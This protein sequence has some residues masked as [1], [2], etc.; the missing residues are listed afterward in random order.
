MGCYEGPALETLRSS[1]TTT[2][3]AILY[4]IQSHSAMERHGGKVSPAIEHKSTCREGTRTWSATALKR[5]ARVLNT[6]PLPRLAS[7]LP[8]GQWTTPTQCTLPLRGMKLCT[9]YLQWKNISF[10]NYC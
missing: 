8:L 3:V 6:G 5:S 2:Y 1:Y 10:V 7:V 9:Q 4:S